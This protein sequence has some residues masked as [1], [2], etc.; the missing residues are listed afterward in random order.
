ME[1]KLKMAIVGAGTWG[2]NHAAIY[3]AH[4][5]ADVVAICDVDTAKSSALAAKMGIPQH[6]SDYEEMF[7]KS[8]C[9]AVAI[10]TPDFAH[11]DIAVKA[12]EYKK[13]MLIEKPLATEKT[14]VFRMMD[15]IEKHQVRAMVDLHNRWNPPFHA[16][17]QSVEAG[18]LGDVYSAY[19]RLNDIKWVATDLLS[20]ASRSSV[21]WFLGSHSLDTLCW[22]FN[23]QISRVYSVSR[24][25][26][27]KRMGVDTTDEYLT[28]IEFKNGGIAQMENGWITPDANPSVNDIK[29]NILGTKG[30]MS[31][32]A[33]HHNLVQKYT[34][35]TVKVPDIL[36][37]HSIFGKPSG[38]AFESIRSFVDCILDDEPFHVSLSDAANVSLGILAIMESAETRTPVDIKE[39]L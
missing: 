28:T 4:P 25:G 19:M 24:S 29:F 34:D 30:M 17:H 16:A 39:W 37:Q 31:V 33:T 32:D 38:F 5:F 22:F 26:V 14:D 11:A 1:S 18:E 15:A 10:V 8:G 21:L 2:E 35:T 6:Y 20:W 9:D 13:D 27:L 12:A 7:K 36:V 23:D 3:K